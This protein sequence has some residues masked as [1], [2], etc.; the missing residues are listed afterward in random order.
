MLLSRT[1]PTSI[2]KIKAHA[3]ISGN[4]KTDKLAKNGTNKEYKFASKPH[5][6]AHTTPFY[7]Q[8]DNWPG[9]AHRPDKGPVRCLDTY[10]TKEDRKNNLEIM[11]QRF[12]NINKWT[13]NPTIDNDLSNE[14]WTNPAI[15]DSQ[16][17]AILK[18]RTGQYM[19]NARKQLFFGIAR[20][21]NKT[22]TICNSQDTD[23][24]LH[25]LLKCNQ[26]HI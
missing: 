17:T 21:P 4:K 15:T 2:N 10:I 5:E 8:K 25:V 12:P 19:G 7:Y 9:P 11:A 18:F 22:C 24:W 14:F 6:F 16:K 1:Q 26:H 3:N 20:F 23:T 13:T